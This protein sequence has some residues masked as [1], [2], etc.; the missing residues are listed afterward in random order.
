VVGIF[1]QVTFTKILAV[2][3]HYLIAN[4]TAIAVAGIFNYLV[5][6][7]WTFGLRNR[8]NDPDARHIPR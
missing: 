6:D 1:L 3:I 5:N 2:Y 4:L 7:A 8:K